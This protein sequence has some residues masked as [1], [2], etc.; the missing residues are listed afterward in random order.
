MRERYGSRVFSGSIN[1]GGHGT[2]RTCIMVIRMS[3]DVS[4]EISSR[5]IFAPTVSDKCMQGQDL[6]HSFVLPGLS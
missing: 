5:L 3:S 2:M 1:G 6:L 4:A